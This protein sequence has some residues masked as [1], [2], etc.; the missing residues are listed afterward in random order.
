MELKRLDTFSFDN[1]IYETGECC[2]VGFSRSSCHVCQAVMPALEV[3]A[4]KYQGKVDFYYVDVELD[5]DLYSRFS[6]KG[7]PTILFF[8]SGEYKGKIAG[9]VDEEQIEEKMAQVL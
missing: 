4:D 6:L 2:V 7:V 3:V 1:V 5:K 9:K 8:K